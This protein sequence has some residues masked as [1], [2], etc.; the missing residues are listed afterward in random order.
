MKQ[1]IITELPSST[2]L[3]TSGSESLIESSMEVSPYDTYEV[4]G[5]DGREMETIISKVNTCAVDIK[6]PC[7]CSLFDLKQ[8]LYCCD[9]LIAHTEFEEHAPILVQDDD[10]VSK[11][12]IYRNGILVAIQERN[13]SD[14]VVLTNTE[15]EELKTPIEFDEYIDCDF[16]VYEFTKALEEDEYLIK[17]GLR[18]QE[19]SQKQFLLGLREAVYEDVTFNM[20]A[21]GKA[22]FFEIHKYDKTYIFNYDTI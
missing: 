17:A 13:Y 21:N 11:I 3:H 19:D 15:L 10:F 5:L 12:T 4:S 22:R 2:D 20:D 8:A 9:A 6:I 1:H 14:D 18:N 7:I 16:S